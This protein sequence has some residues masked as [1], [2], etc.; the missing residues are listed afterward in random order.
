MGRS[1]H[2]GAHDRSSQ[3]ARSAV[4]TACVEPWRPTIEELLPM[5]PLHWEELALERDKGAAGTAL[6][7]LRC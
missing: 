1:S 5:L 6:A 2:T 3:E 7:R 4:M